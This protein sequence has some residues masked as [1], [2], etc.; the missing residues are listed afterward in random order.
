LIIDGEKLG[1]L[2]KTLLQQA[3]SDR[4]LIFDCKKIE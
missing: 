1:S 3:S 2:F 4:K